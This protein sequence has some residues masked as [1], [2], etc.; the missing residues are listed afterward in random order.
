LRFED[1]DNDGR[2]DLFVPN[3]MY[4]EIHNADLI[5]RMMTVDSPAERIRIARTGSVLAE[6]NLAFRNLGDLRFEDVSAA[7]GLNEKG[8][9]FGAAFGDLDGDGD[10]DLVYTNYRKGVT[11]LRND[12]DSGHRLIVA[13]RGTRSNRF[14]VGATVRIETAAGIQVRQLVLARGAL[15]SS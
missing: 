10:L 14:G 1:L 11:L 4:R 13:L 3:G 12:S 7:W 8:V 9:S 15:S 2:L 6:Q 5:A